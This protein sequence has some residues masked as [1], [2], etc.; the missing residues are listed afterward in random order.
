MLLA[1]VPGIC[2]EPRAKVEFVT[3]GGLG[4]MFLSQGSLKTK[5]P[6][7]TTPLFRWPKFGVSDPRN[8][9]HL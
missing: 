2:R 8:K 6:D 5:H 4:G 7:H 9:C 1:G 3:L